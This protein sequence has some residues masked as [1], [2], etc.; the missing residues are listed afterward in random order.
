MFHS[1]KALGQVNARRAIALVR[2]KVPAQ[3]GLQFVYGSGLY[4]LEDWSF[5]FE[6]CFGDW[7]ALANPGS[8][9]DW[10]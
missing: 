8:A 10:A 2:R 3:T 6:K 1:W 9:R 7:Q 4:A 5:A